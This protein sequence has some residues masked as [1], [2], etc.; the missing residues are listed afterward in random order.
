MSPLCRLPGGHRTAG[1]VAGH[2]RRGAGGC[3]VHWRQAGNAAAVCGRHQALA[4]DVLAGLYPCLRGGGGHR[5][6][7]R[8][9]QLRQRSWS[10]A[11]KVPPSR[12]VLASRGGGGGSAAD[13]RP[14][15][16]GAAGPHRLQPPVVCRR[17]AQRAGEVAACMKRL[18]LPI[19]SPDC[20]HYAA[21]RG[22]QGRRGDREA[23]CPVPY[24]AGAFS[25]A[26]CMAL[27]GPLPKGTP[28]A[29]SG[30]DPDDP[31]AH[32]MLDCLEVEDLS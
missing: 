15:A 28:D 26:L 30:H 3:R 19:C 1:A 25:R 22:S 12:R 6:G 10:M 20:G 2:R 32:V 29:E 5:T 9:R 18:S 11:W 27:A 4:G 8:L 17:G 16:A 21:T 7:P 23:R 31:H 24:L 14:G 13:R